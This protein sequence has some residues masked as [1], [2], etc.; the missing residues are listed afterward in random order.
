[1]MKTPLLIT[2]LLTLLLMTGCAYRSIPIGVSYPVTTQHRMQAAHHWDVLAEHTADRLAQTLA[3]TFPKAV[4]KPALFIRYTQ[5]QEQVPFARAFFHMLSSKLVQKGLVVVN[6]ADFGNALMVDYDVQ[7]IDHKDRRKFNPPL[8][9]YAALGGL[10]WLVARG[11]D[12]WNEMSYVLYPL[13]A[14]A[15]AYTAVS[16]YFP[17]DTNT[18]V[19]ITT[20]ATM[21]QQYIFQETNTYYINTGD[22]DHYEPD[23]KTYQVVGCPTP[24]ATCR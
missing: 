17:G 15:E 16:Y 24:P 8:G 22:S 19:V 20:A 3:V 1:M 14:G 7:V 23:G 2:T 12:K 6:N 4:I 5:E 18:E 13:A 11:V 21:G 10:A 9:T